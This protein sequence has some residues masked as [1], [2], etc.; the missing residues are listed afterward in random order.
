VTGIQV[1]QGGTA[2]VWLIGQGLGNVSNL[3]VAVS[4]GATSDVPV[5]GLMQGASYNGVPTIYFQIQVN[6]SATQGA[7]NIMVTN[8]NNELAVFVGAI[9][10]VP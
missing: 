5:S 1:A 4:H 8:T 3:S 10:I 9:Q 2:T 7:R 6:A